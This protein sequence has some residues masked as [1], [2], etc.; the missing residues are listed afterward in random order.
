MSEREEMYQKYAEQ[1]KGEEKPVEEALLAAQEVELPKAEETPAEPA[2]VE[3]EKKTETPAEDTTEPEPSEEEKKKEQEK[4]NNLKKALD[5]ERAKR[6]RLREEK[7][8]LEARIREFESKQEPPKEPE[9]ITDYD[10]ELNAVKS[11]LRS[12]ELMEARREQDAKAAAIREQQ[13]QLTNMKKKTA[14]E[15]ADEGFAGFEYMAGSVTEYLVDLVRNGDADEARSLDNP[16]GWKKIFKEKIYPEFHKQHEESS[17]KR[18]LEDK[19]NLKK[20]ANLNTSAGKAP[21]KK[22]DDNPETWSTERKNQE[23]LKLRRR[24]V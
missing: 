3:P 8:A 6:K 14:K 20:E 24:N 11:K 1:N 17:R 15:L 12:I 16:E 18:V 22:E 13:E 7:E 2:P 10:A 21:Q 4:E 9:P 19:K 23:Y 5:E